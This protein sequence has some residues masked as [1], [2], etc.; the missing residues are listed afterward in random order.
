MQEEEKVDKG[1]HVVPPTP[2]N[3]VDSIARAESQVARELLE[4]R[5]HVVPI[6]HVTCGEAKVNEFKI[7]AVLRVGENILQLE[8]IIDKAETVDLS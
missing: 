1:C 8:I 4:L 5:R 2:C 7:M 6:L 3:L